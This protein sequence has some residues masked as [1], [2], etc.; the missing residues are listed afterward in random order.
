MAGVRVGASISTNEV[1][2]SIRQVLIDDLG[3]NVVAQ[4]GAI[5]LS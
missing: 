3:T 5:L 1:M 4:Y 2:N